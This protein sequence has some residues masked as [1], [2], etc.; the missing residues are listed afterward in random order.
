MPEGL[1]TGIRSVNCLL[2]VHAVMGAYPHV[3][4]KEGDNSDMKSSSK[5]CIRQAISLEIR[6]D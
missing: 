3:K 1:I 2:A 5:V 4:M 6:L